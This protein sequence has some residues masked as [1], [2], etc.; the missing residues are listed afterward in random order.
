LRSRSKFLQ[1]GAWSRLSANL[2][3]P[4]HKGIRE[5]AAKKENA[6]PFVMNDGA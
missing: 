3:L 5:I 2:N 6:P 4:R 1:L